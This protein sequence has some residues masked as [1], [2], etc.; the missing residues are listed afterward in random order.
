MD[1]LPC[2]PPILRILLKLAILYPAP[3]VSCFDN[4]STSWPADELRLSV[5]ESRYSALNW[6]SLNKVNFTPIRGANFSVIVTDEILNGVDG[7]GCCVCSSRTKPRSPPPFGAAT[8][9][10]KLE[11]DPTVY[12][13]WY[14]WLS[15]NDLNHFFMLPRFMK[16]S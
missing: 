4:V 10:M 11:Y 8:Q 9:F 12:V 16:P 1:T 14:A 15:V 5:R 3:N 7:M 6:I 13:H 2:L